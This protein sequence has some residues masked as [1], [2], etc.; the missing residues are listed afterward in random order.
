MTSATSG[1]IVGINVG[2]YVGS[3]PGGD[4]LNNPAFKPANSGTLSD[5]I[6]FVAK[7]SS[8]SDMISRTDI[9]SGATASATAWPAFG[10]I[11]QDYIRFSGIYSDANATN[12]KIR[13]NSSPCTLWA[14]AGLRAIGCNVTGESGIADNY[15]AVRIENTTDTHVYDCKL[16]G[17]TGG[18]NKAGVIVYK[19]HDVKIHHNNIVGCNH[20]I[21][22][23]GA[24]SIGVN[25]IYDIHIYQ[26]LVSGGGDMVRLHGPVVGPLGELT[27]IYQNICY[28]MTFFALFPSSATHDGAQDGLRIFNNTGYNIANGTYA[29]DHDYR[30]EG[31]VPRNNEFFN[32]IFRTD[33][34]YLYST[35]AADSDITEHQQFAD[36]DRNC[37]NNFVRFGIGSGEPLNS[38][39]LNDWQ[40]TYLEDVNSITSDPLFEDEANDDYHLKVGSPC[41][42]LGRDN[43]GQFGPADAVIPAGAYVTGS[44]VIG[45]R[46]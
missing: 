32:N 8:S 3:D 43:L 20:G 36:Y 12:N 28:D 19:S 22:L 38:V 27:L 7:N 6:I 46:I 37:I 39:T 35:S 5:N 14:G 29:L 4:P 45:V 24:T 31:D 41:L 16:N 33:G 40:T 13:P 21:Q 42:T 10:S 9:R 2:V 15:S 25:E 44:E 26:N 34:A 1:D 11:G 18:T 23:K 17:F 30:L